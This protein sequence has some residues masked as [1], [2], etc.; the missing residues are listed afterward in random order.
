MGLMNPQYSDS[1]LSLQ[2]WPW[3]ALTMEKNTS[4]HSD[5]KKKEENRFS[6]EN[7]GT[8]FPPVLIAKIFLSRFHICTPIND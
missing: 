1:P 6:L 7:K 8:I 4:L 2:S 5:G 3:L